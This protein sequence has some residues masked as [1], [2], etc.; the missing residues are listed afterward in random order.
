MAHL[1]L[2]FFFF[3]NMLTLAINKILSKH[4]KNIKIDR[5]IMREKLFKGFKIFSFHLQSTSWY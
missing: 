3:D 2:C 1:F 4:T 5:N